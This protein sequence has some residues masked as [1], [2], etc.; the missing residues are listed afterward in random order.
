[1][2]SSSDLTVLSPV[3]PSCWRVSG[4]TTVRSFG[5]T[6]C[7]LCSEPNA[8]PPPRWCRTARSIWSPDLCR[9]DRWSWVKHTEGRQTDSRGFRRQ[10]DWR[11]SETVKRTKS[12]SWCVLP[13]RNS[14]YIRVTQRMS[15]YV[16]VTQRTADRITGDSFHETS[17]LCIY[18]CWTRFGHTARSVCSS[19]NWLSSDNTTVFY[20]LFYF[21]F[22]SINHFVFCFGSPLCWA[23]LEPCIRFVVWQPYIIKHILNRHVWIS[24]LLALAS[25]TCTLDTYAIN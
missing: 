3:S 12:S 19:K 24:K 22:L 1:M 20:H 11:I 21:M 7:Q 9:P 14:A 25:F 17:P 13:Q 18:T 23:S 5:D 6:W 2:L 4:K 16:R 10:P 8:P 15:A